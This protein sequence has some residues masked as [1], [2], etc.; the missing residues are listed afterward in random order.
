MCGGS[1][2]HKNWVLTAAHCDTGGLTQ[3]LIGASSLSPEHTYQETPVEG[4]VAEFHNIKRKIKHPNY[5]LT[6]GLE[7][8]FML[9][10][11]EG[12]PP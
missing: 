9:M 8:D 11:L 6:G 4:H 1:L 5:D 3:V 12:K 10:E 7:N 2:V